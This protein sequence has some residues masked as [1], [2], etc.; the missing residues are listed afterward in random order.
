MELSIVT[1]DK[2]IFSGEASYV[3]LPGTEGSFGVLNNHAALI[4]TLTEGK[5]V[6]R[7]ED[8]KEETSEEP[9]ALGQLQRQ[10]DELQ[11]QLL[12]LSRKKSG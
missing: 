9:A 8:G 1:P 12:E 11:R 6:V 7:D 10:V 2:S 4:A 5:V 3:G